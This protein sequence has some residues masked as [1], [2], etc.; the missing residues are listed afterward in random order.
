MESLGHEEKIILL[1]QER[2]MPLNRSYLRVHL[3]TNKMVQFLHF[4]KKTHLKRKLDPFTGIG[5]CCR[6]RI[7]FSLCPKDFKK[8][9]RLYVTFLVFL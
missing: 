6:N 4:R 1:R 3:Q 9:S 2:H 8:C 5:R 7:I